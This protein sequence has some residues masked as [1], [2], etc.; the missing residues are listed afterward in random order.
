MDA[1]LQIRQRLRHQQGPPGVT[2]VQQVP[3]NSA[4]WPCTRCAGAP[5]PAGGQ[6]SASVST[7]RKV[8]R[9]EHLIN[10]VQ[11]ADS[12]VGVPTTRPTETADEPQHIPTTTS[13]APATAFPTNL[14]LMLSKPT[15]GP[16]TWR[17][18]KETDDTKRWA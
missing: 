17:N 3:L 4:G 15:R 14:P 1:E 16:Q 12:V 10:E 5:A 2:G 13:T 6:K 7:L 9:K 11:T 8:L 18:T